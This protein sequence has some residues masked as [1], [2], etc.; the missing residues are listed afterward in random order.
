MPSTT[1]IGPR[2]IWRDAQ[3]HIR[4][5]QFGE[6]AY[7]ETELAIQELLAAAGHGNFSRDLV[8]ID[9]QGVEAAADWRDLKSPETYT[10][11]GLARGFTSPGGTAADTTRAYSIPQ[12]LGL[13]EWALTGNW[14][15]GKEAAVS[16]GPGGRVAFRFHARDVNLIMAPPKGA[17]VPF[18]ALIDGQPPGTSHGVDVDEQGSGVLDRPM[19]YQLIRALPVT[20][21]LFEIEFARPGVAVF[22]FT[23]G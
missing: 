9:P 3:G 11:Y 19:M 13:N 2:S 5:H 20:D 1:S 23:F 4:Y 14:T 10:G 15:I 7:Q 17:S 16:N 12:R 6:G 21:H 18:R 22:D 8:A